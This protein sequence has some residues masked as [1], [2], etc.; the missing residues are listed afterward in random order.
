MK[1]R[2]VC[3]VPGC[4]RERERWQRI[5]TT[6]FHALSSDLRNALITA[7]RQKRHTDHRR[8]CKAAREQIDRKAET[9]TRN[10][11]WDDPAMMRD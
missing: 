7:K 2:H 5:C 1:R 4:T 8:H 9:R 11:R 10:D 6:C 3:D